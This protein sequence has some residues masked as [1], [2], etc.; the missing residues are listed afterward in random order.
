MM[1]KEIDKTVLIFTDG[2]Q[3]AY[4]DLVTAVARHF[5]VNRHEL[6]AAVVR[7]QCHAVLAESGHEVDPVRSASELARCMADVLGVELAAAVQWIGVIQETQAARKVQYDT[8][9]FSQSSA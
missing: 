9:V 5:R 6:G 4:D 1:V 3:E 2:S 7:L 8:G